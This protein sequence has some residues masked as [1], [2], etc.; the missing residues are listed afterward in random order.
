MHK[1]LKSLW[2]NIKIRVA[3]LSTYY[4]LK[5]KKKK[6]SLELEGKSNSLRC[7]LDL[8]QCCRWMVV[9]GDFIGVDFGEDW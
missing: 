9:I 1:M 3:E 6:G 4:N 7:S 5:K 2:K 8:W